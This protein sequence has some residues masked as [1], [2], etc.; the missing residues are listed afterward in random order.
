M[1]LYLVIFAL[2]TWIIVIFSVP[3]GSL[4]QEDR[5]IMKNGEPIYV[6]RSGV[7]SSGAKGMFAGIVT[8]G[9]SSYWAFYV[10]G[11]RGRDWLYVASWGRGAFYQRI[12]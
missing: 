7:Y 10:R 11:N 2:L 4:S 8:R 9:E 6:Q 1:I 5:Y 3:I 12:G